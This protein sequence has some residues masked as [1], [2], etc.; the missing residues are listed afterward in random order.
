MNGT[1]QVIGCNHMLNAVLVGPAQSCIFQHGIVFNRCTSYSFS[2]VAVVSPIHSHL[3]IFTQI[4]HR[5]EGVA[6]IRIGVA[7]KERKG[8]ASVNQCIILIS[9]LPI[10]I[11]ICFFNF[12]ILWRMRHCV[13]RLPN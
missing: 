10:E 6:I 5:I 4:P 13:I 11:L 12:W 1:E 7:V 8:V 3:F 2:A 9:G